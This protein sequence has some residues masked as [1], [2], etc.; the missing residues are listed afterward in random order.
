MYIFCVFWSVPAVTEA[1]VYSNHQRFWNQS[2]LESVV[3]IE[4][5]HETKE[6]WL[7]AVEE[8]KK[9]KVL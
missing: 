3:C 5:S 7:T 9:A 2:P 6:S 8:G 4:K 1:S